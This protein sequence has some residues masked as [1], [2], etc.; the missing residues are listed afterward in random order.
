[1]VTTHTKSCPACAEAIQEA[2]VVCRFCGYDYQ[3][4]GI[5]QQTPPPVITAT[6]TNGL[7]VASLVLGIVW[8]DWI[9]SVLAVVFGHI[10]RRQI[11]N[12]EG[13][14]TGS[15]MAMAGLVLGWIG[16]AIL[17][18]AVAAVIVAYNNEETLDDGFNDVSTF[19]EAS[20]EQVE[21]E[22]LG[23]F[24]IQVGDCVNL[25]ETDLIESLEAVPCNQPH[26]AETYEVFNMR[27]PL[28]PGDNAVQDA[29]S[30]GCYNAFEL[31]VGRAYETSALD[32]YWLY[33][34]LDSWNQHHD[35]EIVCM[36]T[37]LDGT[38]LYGPMRDSG[39]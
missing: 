38:K 4:G 15:G 11:R 19:L 16:V 21:N 10:A 36:V 20:T 13:A 17:T 23:A 31:F 32:I 5:V 37:S 28:Y 35:R 3:V 26:D 29:A 27:N 9:G 14:Q 33:P 2:A 1:M 25:P 18:A 22:N 39:L 12:S 7:A 24:A 8:I 34:T 30:S 6:K